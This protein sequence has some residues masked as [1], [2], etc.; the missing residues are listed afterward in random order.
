MVAGFRLAS[1]PSAIAVR[2][3]RSAGRKKRT[4]LVDLRAYCPGRGGRQLASCWV[5]RNRR[6]LR[7]ASTR[8]SSDAEA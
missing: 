7:I 1:M 5:S 2:S 4:K 8:A 6:P 3:G